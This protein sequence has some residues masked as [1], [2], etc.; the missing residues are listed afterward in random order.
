MVVALYS[1]IQL[2]ILPFSLGCVFLI[3]KL[4]FDVFEEFDVSLLE[5][6]VPYEVALGEILVLG[7]TPVLPLFHNLFYDLCIVS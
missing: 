6:R 5:P 2:Q 4:G 1:R 7:N 3:H